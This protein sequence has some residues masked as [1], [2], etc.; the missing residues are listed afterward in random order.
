MTPDQRHRG[1]DAALLANRHAVNQAAREKHPARWSGRTRNWHPV[2][3]VWL[4]PERHH[5]RRGGHGGADA[6]PHTAGRGAPM[7]GQQQRAV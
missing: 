5:T 4:N 1:R 6:L 3:A 7:A 2:G